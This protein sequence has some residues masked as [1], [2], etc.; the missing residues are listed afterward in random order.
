MGVGDRFI[1]LNVNSSIL[2]SS[3]RY[4][5]TA[6]INGTIESDGFQKKWNNE[7][8]SKPEHSHRQWHFT[9]R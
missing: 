1:S 8:L 2:N 7:N 4:T 6:W 9:V 3:Y 5:K